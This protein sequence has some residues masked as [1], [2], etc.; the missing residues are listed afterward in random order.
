MLSGV[1]VGAVVGTYLTVLVLFSLLASVGSI[2]TYIIIVVA[3]R[4]DPDP[5]GNRTSA[6]FHVGSAFV[7]LWIGVAGVI[8]I[9]VTLF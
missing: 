3:N 6:V 4:A 2:V 8:M 5:S 7:A 9:F 1:Q